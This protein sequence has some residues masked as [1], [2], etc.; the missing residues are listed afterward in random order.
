MDFEV[1]YTEAQQR[2]R[3]EVRAWLEA[4]VPAGHHAQAVDDADSLTALQELR[5]ARAASSARRAGSIRARRRS[6][7]AAG[8]TSITRSSSRRRPIASACR[9][10]RTTTAA[11]GSARATILVWG[12]EEQ[13]QAFLPPIYRGEVRDLAA[14]D[15]ARRRL[16][17]GRR[18]DDGH[19]RRR[20]VRPQRPED[21]RRQRPRRRPHLDDRVHRPGRRAPREP[22]AGS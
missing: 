1:T 6:T 13:K 10:R 21:L 5:D 17:P 11:G 14:A 20:R 9:C 12:T 16:R 19:P 8:S 2:F 15:R 4:N 18:A 22:V 3:R 7:A